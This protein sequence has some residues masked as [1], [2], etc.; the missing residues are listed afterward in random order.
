M[1]DKPILRQTEKK[2]VPKFFF[3]LQ[4]VFLFNVLKVLVGPHL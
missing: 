1:V 3:M 2:P 4:E